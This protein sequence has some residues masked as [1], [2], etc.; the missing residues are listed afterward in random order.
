MQPGVDPDQSYSEWDGA[1]PEVPT[2]EVDFNRDGAVLAVRFLHPPPPKPNVPTA[3]PNSA[4]ESRPR[5]RRAKA[6]SRR[7]PPSDD[8]DLPPRSP[9]T[10]AERALL[11]AEIDRLVRRGL[12]DQKVADRALFRAVAAWGSAE[13]VR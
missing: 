8:P 3:Q 5:R 9:L 10:R 11:K 1:A 4:R 12:E 2:L 13:V 7:G 6:A